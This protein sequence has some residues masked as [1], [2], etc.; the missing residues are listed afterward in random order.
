MRAD[1]A[2]WFKE[3]EQQRDRREALEPMDELLAATG[4]LV[5]Q[6]AMKG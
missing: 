2:E 3:E 4:E 5:F 1:V 6:K